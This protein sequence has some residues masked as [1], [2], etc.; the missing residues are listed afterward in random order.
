[1][2]FKTIDEVV[3]RANDTVY[4]LAAGVLTKDLDKAIT[5]SNAIRAG[6]LWWVSFL[7]NSESSKGQ[8]DQHKF[9]AGRKIYFIL[10]YFERNSGTTINYVSDVGRL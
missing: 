2:K 3:K 1:M 5:V 6:T 9:A 10:L 7:H 8:T 4:G